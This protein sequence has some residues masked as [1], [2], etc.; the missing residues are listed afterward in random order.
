MSSALDLGWF[1]SM[2]D[3]KRGGKRG[4]FVGGIGKG[5]LTFISEGSDSAGTL[6]SFF[7]ETLDSALR[8]SSRVVWKVDSDMLANVQIVIGNLYV[9]YVYEVILDIA[10]VL[11][12]SCVCVCYEVI[13]VCQ[14]L[15]GE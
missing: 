9:S 2:I 6:P 13:F 4:R 7:W 15:R 5:M 14:A 10:R 1:S 12:G 3:C 8:M 11:K